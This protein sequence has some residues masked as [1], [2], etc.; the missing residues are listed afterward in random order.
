ME[1]F[2]LGDIEKQ[3]KELINK[4]HSYHNHLHNSNERAKLKFSDPPVKIVKTPEEWEINK[5]FNPFY[6]YKKRKQ[7]AKSVS[8]NI[9]N[10]TYR[11]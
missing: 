10:G 5:K 3:A 4:F 8:R 1:K 7:I 2:L 9:L 6:V 11:P